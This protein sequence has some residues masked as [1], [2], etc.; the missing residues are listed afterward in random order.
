MV[1]KQL[2]EDS[3]CS[4]LEAFYTVLLCDI[5]FLEFAYC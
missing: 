1:I 4:D 2:A 5:G 3:R